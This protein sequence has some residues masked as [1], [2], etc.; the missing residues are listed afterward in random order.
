MA[1]EPKTPE[2][3]V[4]EE[5]PEVATTETPIVEVTPEA[6]TTTETPTVKVEPKEEPEVDISAIEAEVT[7]KVSDKIIKSLTG[8]SEAE[9]EGA[10]GEQS[11]WAKEGRNPKDYDEIAQWATDLALKRQEAQKAEETE[12]AK[13]Q[14][15]EATKL[16][17]ERAE[18]FNK[19]WDTQLN[20]LYE[21]GKLPKIEN[22]KDE[23]D[24]GVK[25]RKAMFSK[26]IEVNE[27][28][29]KEGKEPIYSLKEIY[30]EHPINEEPGMSAPVSAGRGAVPAEGEGYEYVGSKSFLDILKGAIGK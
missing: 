9:I 23:N 13:E 18:A 21:S 20:E 26:M 7:K 2:P 4:P 17:T 10:L 3:K 11:P 1:D 16:Q 19:Y 27:Q 28:R 24:L 5:T 22:A 25:A 15:K 6:E 29:T 30:Y 12:K 8:G 14:E